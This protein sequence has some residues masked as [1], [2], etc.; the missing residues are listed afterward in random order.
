VLI[1]AI[2]AAAS[3]KVKRAAWAITAAKKKK[4][5]KGGGGLLYF[6]Q[7]LKKKKKKISHL[8]VTT[9]QEA[10]GPVQNQADN[11]QKATAVQKEEAHLSHNQ[12]GVYSQIDVVQRGADS[13]HT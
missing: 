8:G 4:K 11:P 10:Q 2:T 9:Q 7:T 13:S 5:K 6:V 12:K 3:F 1:A